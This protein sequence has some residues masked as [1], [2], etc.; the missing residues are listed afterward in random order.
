[1]PVQIL[2]IW[3]KFQQWACC[4]SILHSSGQC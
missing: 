4:S 3:P 2:S 1:M